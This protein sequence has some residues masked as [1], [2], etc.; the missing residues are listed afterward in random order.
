MREAALLIIRIVLAAIWFPTIGYGQAADSGAHT[1]SAG[2]IKIGSDPDFPPAEIFHVSYTLDGSDP[3]TRPVTFIWN[4]G[5]GASSTY[6]HVLALGP[7]VLRIT[8]DGSLPA[9]PARLVDNPQTW[10]HFTDLVFVDPVGTGYSRALPDGEEEAEPRKFYDAEKDLEVLGRF[11]RNW[12][13]Q[14]GRWASPKGIVGE[15]YGGRRVAA[16]SLMLME[17][18]AINLNWAVMISPALNDDIGDID[19]PYG[20]LGAMAVLPSYAAVAAFHD[21]GAEAVSTGMDL[22]DY[23]AEVEDFALGEYASGLV[24][25]ARISEEAA[26]VFYGRVAETIGL[27]VDDVARR[28]GRVGRGAYVTRLL[29]EEGLVIDPYDGTQTSRPPRP[30]S[31]TSFAFDRTLTSL[32][33]IMAAPF[34]DYLGSELGMQTDRAY[35]FLNEDVNR[36][37]DREMRHGGPEDLARAMAINP[38]LRLLVV[39][40]IH[41]VVTP[42]FKTRYVLEQTIRD[43]AARA[44]LEFR[45]YVGG[46]MFYMFLDSRKALFDDI[47]AFYDG[48]SGQVELEK[49]VRTP[50]DGE[51][52]VL[53]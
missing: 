12:L 35:E 52:S 23:L 51:Q 1:A 8:G 29:E 2:F 10:L 13:T 16:L 18:F 42:Y 20:V 17:D 48:V 26:R 5:P 6:L 37:F 11:I 19:S 15:S 31:A 50:P 36:R 44:R 53:E 43:E 32:S 34:L 40:G 27:P 24:Q 45:N 21:K 25:S 9:V 39:H 49:R 14:N 4:G 3:E 7:R 46:H 38:D 47:Q 28:Q 41:D 22:Q 30:E 33:G